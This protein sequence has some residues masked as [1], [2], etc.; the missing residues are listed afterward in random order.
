L[1]RFVDERR[2]KRCAHVDDAAVGEHHEERLSVARVLLTH[3]PFDVDRAVSLER[4]TDVVCNRLRETFRRLIG[5]CG[6]GASH[7]PD[8]QQCLDA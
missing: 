5:N 8:E 2:G 3:V 6:V 1:A 7:D 4:L